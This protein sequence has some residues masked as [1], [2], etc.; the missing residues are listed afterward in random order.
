MEPT[1]SQS[2]CPL[3]ATIVMTAYRGG[4]SMGVLI[5]IDPHKSV[6]AAAAIDDQGELAG[7]ETFPANQ[8]GLRALER[9]AKR[10]PERRG[11]VEGAAGIGRPVAQRLPMAGGKGVGVPPQIS[12]QTK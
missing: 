4:Q 7:H 10:F 3:H 12:P 8:K 5:G 11:A 2:D 9:G 6:N 1:D